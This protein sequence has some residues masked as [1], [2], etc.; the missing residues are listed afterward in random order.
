MEGNGPSP[1]PPR[2]CPGCAPGR[3]RGAGP[4]SAPPAQARPA[5]A[6]SL[7][8]RSSCG[9]KYVMM[10]SAPAGRRADGRQG[11]RRGLEAAWPRALPLLTCAPEGGHGFHDRG[12]QAEGA[13][14]RPVPQHGELSRDVVHGQRVRGVLQ[15]TAGVSGTAGHR[16]S[17]PGTEALQLCSVPCSPPVLERCH[18][19]PQPTLLHWGGTT[20]CPQPGLTRSLA[21]RTRSR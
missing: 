12:L 9:V 20:R 1:P 5:A 6:S 17:T 11:P 10:V 3:G 16:L 4:R 15:A 18:G 21:S 2:R 8:Q 19:C 13:C 14:L 7:S